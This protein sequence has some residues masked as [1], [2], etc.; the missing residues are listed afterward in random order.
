MAKKPG[1]PKF[2]RHRALVTTEAVLLISLAKDL[3]SAEVKHSAIA[4]A[5]KVLFVMGATVGLFGVLFLVL[6]RFAASGVAKTHEVVQALPLP[7]PLLAIHGA[8]LAG[9]FYLYAWHQGM[10]VWPMGGAH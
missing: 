2:L 5:W 4:N 8:A 6:E 3:L 10:P 1:S 7:V 9:L